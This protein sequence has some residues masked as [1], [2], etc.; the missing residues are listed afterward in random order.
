MQVAVHV[1]RDSIKIVNLRFDIPDASPIE[2]EPE[3]LLKEWQ[4][5]LGLFLDE[6]TGVTFPLYHLKFTRNGPTKNQ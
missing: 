3:K 4:K 2:G 5:K 6:T 1:T